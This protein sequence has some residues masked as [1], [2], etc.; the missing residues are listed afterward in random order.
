MSLRVEIFDGPPPVAEADWDAVH[1][2]GLIGS[3]RWQKFWPATQPATWPSCR[4]ASI[5][6]F[7]GPRIVG[8]CSTFR[9]PYPLPFRHSWQRRLARSAL[10][11]ANPVN[12]CSPPAV[13]PDADP[14]AVIA[15]LSKGIDRLRG[16]WLAP[17]S[18]LVM[19]DKT[20]DR[21]LID[22]L[23]ANGYFCAPGIT[24]TRL[25][26][27]WDSFDDYLAGA[28]RA[29]PRHFL[30]KC[31]RKAEKASVSFEVA[32]SPAR[33]QQ[34]IFSLIKN[35]ADRNRSEPLYAADF[36]TAVERHLEPEDIV[37]IL[38]WVGDRL[39]GCT[40]NY[41]DKDRLV[42]K[43]LGLDYELAQPLN[44]YR[45]IIA[46]GVRA[47]I[48]IGV[49]TVHAGFSQYDIKRRLGFQLAETI[50][51]VKVWPKLLSPIYGYRSTAMKTSASEPDGLETPL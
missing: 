26:I 41:R 42:M 47:A 10:W 35:V 49:K 11:P 48:Q 13:H 29:K 37:V 6:A 7:D 3:Y 34:A 38:A 43:T 15:S 46:E 1:G 39:A 44:I 20:R 21:R 36:L 30:K 5:A 28:L 18:R 50:T 32:K 2:G 9:Y 14:A 24:D 45:L 17:A 19:L 33:H 31:Y 22:R 8:H 4:T 27:R 25:D 12:L 23:A 16:R 51:A 40:I